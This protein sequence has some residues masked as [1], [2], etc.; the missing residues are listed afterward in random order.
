M[1]LGE[2][3]REKQRLATQANIGANF[4]LADV[5]NI[6]YSAQGWEKSKLQCFCCKGYIHI[7][8]KCPQIVW[9]YCKQPGHIIKDCHTQ[10]PYCKTKAFQVDI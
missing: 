6:A 2:L 10:P 4:S 3:L 5:V 7:A 1:C 8:R 9:N